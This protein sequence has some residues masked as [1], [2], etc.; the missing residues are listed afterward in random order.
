MPKPRVL[1]LP[2]W[3]PN[4]YD[5]QDG[6]FVA[7]HIAAI[8]PH[9]EAA[10]LFATVTRGPLNSWLECES[11]LTGPVPTL[12][13][14]YRARI[15]GFAFID[16]VLKLG[17]YFWCMQ[18]GY[19][20]LVRHWGAPP[21]LAH[22]H[23]LLRTGLWAWWLRISTGLPFLITEHWTLYQPQNAH[24]I[25]WLRRRLTRA[26][27]HRSAGLHTV[28]ENLRE[29]LVKLGVRHEHSVVIPNVVDTELFY[30]DPTGPRRPD[31]LLHVAAFNEEAKNLSG[32]LRVVARLR[33]ERPGLRL[34]VAG[35]GPAQPQLQQ[36]AADLGLLQDGT[37]TF[38]GKLVPA[39]VAAEMR[40]AACFVLFSNYENLPCVLIE[41]QASGLPVVATRVGGV[42]ELVPDASRGLLVE[43]RDEVALAGA[44]QTILDTLELYD[45]AALHAHA[46]RHFS[47]EAVGKQFLAF[48]AGA[49]PQ[50]A[51]SAAAAAS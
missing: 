27:V 3:Y 28:S 41:A 1:M 31:S 37:V 51:I 24:R 44:L 46:V 33:R 22:V 32:L 34:R 16:K 8:A 20:R 35:Y 10:V 6:D 7:R 5:D 21:T 23:V 48:Y 25:S 19:R 26:V 38:L 50:A 49:V 17:L 29:A 18:L 12:R 30:P 2:K 36:L 43:A 45:P 47:Y 11:A 40:Q 15:T 14:Y 42:P 39:A 9:A 13:Y 4:R